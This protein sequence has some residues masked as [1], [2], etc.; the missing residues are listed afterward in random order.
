MIYAD[1]RYYASKYIGDAI[2]EDNFLR[3]AARASRYIDYITQGRAA[4][5]RKLDAVKLCCCAL[6]EQ[7]QLIESARRIN[8]E[9]LSDDYVEVKSETVGGWSRSYRS[10][11]DTAAEI[12]ESAK[13]ELTSIAYQYLSSTG[14][15]YRGGGRC[16]CE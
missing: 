12:S 13:A 8:A 11:A 5:S 1:Y 15:L 9:G 14:L 7:Y 4:K 10:A 2:A 3:L 6:A 16:R